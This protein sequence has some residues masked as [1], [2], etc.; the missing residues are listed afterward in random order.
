MSHDPATCKDCIEGEERLNDL[1]LI[2]DANK[3]IAEAE[4]TIQQLKETNAYQKKVID[5]MHADFQVVNNELIEEAIKREWCAE[6]DNFVVDVNERL[7]H[8]KLD[9]LEIEH[10]VEVYLTREQEVYV[11][12]KVMARDAD[13]AK[14]II[15]SD[16]F[17]DDL[18]E[19]YAG[20][21]DWT[22][23]NYDMD[24]IRAKEV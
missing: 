11:K 10:E 1:K 24:V 13:H 5:E 9:K 20:E 12:V 22:S 19:E 23:R 6:Y 21:D 3:K 17:A 18:A 2:A 8:F 15:N 16:Y 4:A 7:K 14:D